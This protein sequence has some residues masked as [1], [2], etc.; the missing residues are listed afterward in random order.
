MDYITRDK[1]KKMTKKVLSKVLDLKIAKKS[2]ST[3]V[4]FDPTVTIHYKYNE[5]G[6]KG[7]GVLLLNL[8]ELDYH[9][10]QFILEYP[11]IKGI[12]YNKSV[13]VP[14][15][16]FELVNNFSI[17]IFS[18]K[19]DGDYSTHTK[20]FNDNIEALIYILKEMK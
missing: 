8:Y 9:I 11:M 10:T 1:Y 14:N 17:E 2:F 3:D 13:V 16:S 7:K 19:V 6:V 18:S 5:D 15:D 4:E 12:S 20:E